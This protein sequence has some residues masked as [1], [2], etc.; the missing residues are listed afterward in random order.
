MSYLMIDD[1]GDDVIHDV[2]DDVNDGADAIKHE[3]DNVTAYG[4]VVMDCGRIG[5]SSRYQ[6]CF[7]KRFSSG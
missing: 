4:S 3:C 1:D 7:L 2:K 5:E 6:D